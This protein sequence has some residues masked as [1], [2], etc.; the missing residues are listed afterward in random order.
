M[1]FLNLDTL[2]QDDNFIVWITSNYKTN[3]THWKNYKKNLNKSEKEIFNKAIRIISKI[4]SLHIDEPAENLSSEFIKNQYIKLLEA[5]S[6][7]KNSSKKVIVLNTFLKYAAAIIL[8]I[9]ATTVYFVSQTNQNSFKNHLATST[10]NNSDILIQTSDNQYF[11][12]N[13]QTNN[14]WLNNNGI[15]VDVDN[16]KITFISS[17]DVKLSET[18]AF[19]IIV[20]PG[21]KYHVNMVDGTNVELNSNT[22][23][24]FNNSTFS[25]NRN[26]AVKGEAFFDVSH[27]K[28]RPFIVQS[29]NLKIEVLGTEFN[30]SN[31]SNN[32]YTSTT[33]VDGK[34]KVSNAQGD[35]KIILPGNQ[36]KLYHNQNNIL[37]NEIDVQEVVAW[38]S[39][40]MI[41]YNE[42]LQNL[43]PKLNRWYNVNFVLDEK[44][45]DIQFTGTLKKGND[46]RHFLE[47]LKYT[48]GIS[49]KINNKQVELFVNNKQ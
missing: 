43:I 2:L 14:K 13:E 35:S 11:K 18:E 10:Y 44:I 31:Y 24:T 42:K 29:S 9:S 17:D 3:N 25:K 16:E 12:I 27:N 6:T 7:Q 34:I 33:L 26:V 20:P 4:R 19:K 30:V 46:L 8:M 36:A 45:N 48:E 5:N 15:F 49:Y 22:T 39:G 32:N 28:N 23:F 1:I 38:T 47:M 21:K 41:F 37:I 40:R